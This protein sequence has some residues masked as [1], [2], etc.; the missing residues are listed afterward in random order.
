MRSRR[1]LVFLTFTTTL[2]ALGMLRSRVVAAL[3]G[4]WT[5]TVADVELVATELV[6]NACVHGRPPAE[7]RLFLLQ[8]PG[9]LRMEVSDAGATLPRLMRPGVYDKHG[10][11]LRLVARM[12]TDWGIART[13][14][15]KVVW[16]EFAV[17]D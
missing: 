13:G 15:G 6:T 5:Q 9:R 7:F 10:R 4:V 1:R 8:G 14:T 16:A 17:P 12:S 3:A 11:G 2:P